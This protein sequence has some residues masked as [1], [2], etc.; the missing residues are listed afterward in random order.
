M[1]ASLSHIGL[2][3]TLPT[4][5]M[6]QFTEQDEKRIPIQLAQFG[7]TVRFTGENT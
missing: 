7:F 3:S 6:L 5:P 2:Q 1:C 4:L